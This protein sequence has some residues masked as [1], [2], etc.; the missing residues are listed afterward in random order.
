[1]DV[2]NVFNA[3]Q[4]RLLMKEDEFDDLPDYDS[5]FRDDDVSSIT[6]NYISGVMISMLTSS[7]VDCEVK[8]RSVETKDYKI[9]ICCFSA[10]HA[11]LRSKSKDWLAWN[12][13][14]MS[15]WSDMS[16]SKLISVS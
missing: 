2:H 11:A 15:E 5:L 16:T 4:V 1:M 12:L 7:A 14:N 8:P 9:S 6:R 13:D 10:K 3:V